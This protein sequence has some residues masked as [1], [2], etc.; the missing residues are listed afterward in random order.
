MEEKLIILDESIAAI[1]KMIEQVRVDI[2]EAQAEANYHVGA[3]ESRYDTFK[4]E[5][6][7][8]VAA[9]ELRLSDL[10]S[11]L[12]ESDRLKQSLKNPHEFSKIC[13]GSAFSIEKEG[14][15]KS[16]F[17]LPFAHKSSCILRG[18]EY[19]LSSDK[20]P[21][22]TVFKDM[23]IGDEAEDEGLFYEYEVQEIF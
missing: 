15:K 22:F 10:A 2:K 8:M 20:S 23:K 14:L 6:Q 17:I 21:V 19:Y 1:K 3:M 16:F 13:L 18:K 4:E 5:A 9:S 7:Y 12:N 11:Y